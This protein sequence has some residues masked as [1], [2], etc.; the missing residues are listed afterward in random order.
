[1]VLKR[2]LLFIQRGLCRHHYVE[3][4][5]SEQWILWQCDKC[6]KI[7]SKR[8]LYG[9]QRAYNNA[10][11]RLCDNILYNLTRLNHEKSRK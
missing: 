5:K 1:M 6:S 3:F 7:Q 11:D 2:L 4:Y 10:T 9:L 8:T